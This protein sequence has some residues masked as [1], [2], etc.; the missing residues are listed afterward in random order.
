MSALRPAH[1]P[2]PFPQI[3]IVDISPY[4]VSVRGRPAKSGSR[5]GRRSLA[6]LV[7]AVFN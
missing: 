1:D 4:R 3:K 5:R 2:M 7:A 6:A